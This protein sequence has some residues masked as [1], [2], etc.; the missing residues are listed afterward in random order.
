MSH[1]ANLLP[2]TWIITQESKSNRVKVKLKFRDWIIIDK[3]TL[4]VTASTYELEGGA[5]FIYNNPISKFE[6]D[7]YSI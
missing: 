7:F 5:H 6:F 1:L 4:G 2:G 3:I